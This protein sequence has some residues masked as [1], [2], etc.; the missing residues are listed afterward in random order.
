MTP[1]R[2]R[3]IRLLPWAA[4]PLFYLVSLVV[5]FAWT[6]PFGALRD[7]VVTQYNAQQKRSSSPS[8]LQIETLSSHMI[9]G[10]R[11]TGVRLISPSPD[12]TKPAS[13]L[14]IENVRAHVSLLGLAF[15]TKDVS[16]QAD[17]FDGTIAGE[18]VDTPKLRSID[19]SLR[20][21][22]LKR[23]SGLQAALGLPL[24]GQVTG[25]LAFQLPDGKA[26]RA[27]GSIDLAV[28][29][30]VAGNAT[31]LTVKTAL[32]PFTLPR[33][34]VG[35]LTLLG[36]A[37]DGVLKFS[38]IAA[39][40]ADV[41]ANGDGRVQLRENATD[42]RLDVTVKFRL[43]DAYRNKNE[44]TKLLFGTPGGKDKPM[45][46]SDPMIARSKTSDGYY[47]LAIRGTLAKP[48]VQ[49]GGSSNAPS[50]R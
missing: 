36:E 45:L 38:K 32:G 37:K 14:R 46:E 26:S 29:E 31:D 3:L 33:L 7:A 49:A 50:L 40:G 6:F 34:K 39:A 20:G 23:V 43:N 5:F 10:V 16:F 22:E 2:A 4:F 8:E 35:T 28:S 24:E 1:M 25:T 13:E 12:P 17:A 19:L 27:S 18:F 30:M 9:T 41:D 48:E 15:G 11:A 42:A 44:K 47:A 21:V